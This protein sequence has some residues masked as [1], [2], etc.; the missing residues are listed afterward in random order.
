MSVPKKILV[1]GG[2]V[3]A[4]L[5]AVKVVTNRFRGGLMA[6]LAHNLHLKNC[7]VVYLT[8][9]KY[10][11]P[12]LHAIKIIYHD[13]FEDYKQ[14]VLELAPQMDAVVLGAA[15]ANLIPLHPIE[16][17]FPSHN[18]KPGDVIPIDFTI[19]PRIIDE[20]K[21]VAPKTHLFGFKLLK[22][23]SHE[24]L[25]RSAYGVLIESKATAVFA[26]DASNLDSICMIT[27]ERAEHPMKR[28]YIH[29][30]ISNFLTDEYYHT[31]SIP[32]AASSNL[33]LRQLLNRF[34][35]FWK[36][37]AE[38]YIFGTVAL[39]DSAG[40]F[41][42]TTRGKNEINSQA[43]VFSVNHENRTVC[44]SDKATLNAPLLD[45]IF[46]TNPKINAIVHLHKQI[47]ELHTLSY[48]PPGTIRDSIRDVK[49]S[50]N[51]ENH[52]CFLLLSG[53]KIKGLEINIEDFVRLHG[54][55]M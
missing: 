8:A 35:P 46:K 25:V 19:A 1:T 27:K 48:A 54:E 15:V 7:E 3:H 47:D 24:E 6:S 14:L 31:N 28:R 50:F 34:Q 53:D 13:G 44:S 55:L 49:S 4:Y 18:Y 26:N 40:G 42:T 33:E 29:E 45:Y 5:D 23:V 12:D 17:K 2:P 22:D 41:Y 38:E 37:T 9:I 32:T 10:P 39:R 51:I 36:P 20:V 43:H 21:K 11:V 52:G 30:I 16:G